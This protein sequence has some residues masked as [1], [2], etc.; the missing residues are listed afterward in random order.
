MALIF[1]AAWTPTGASAITLGDVSQKWTMKLEQLGGQAVEEVIPLFRAANPLRIPRGNV[2]GD[3][4]FTSAKS[5]ANRAQAVTF[6]ASQFALLNGQGAL[7]LT[8][9]TAALT[10]AQAVFRGLQT[11][12]INGLRWTLRYSFGITTM[13]IAG[14]SSLARSADS[15][16][17]SADSSAVTADTM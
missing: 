8:I 13:V 4:I 1:T 15:S 14:G 10:M 11:T 3:C 17:T 12:E 7:T 9:D 6:F 16:T 2:S 5:F